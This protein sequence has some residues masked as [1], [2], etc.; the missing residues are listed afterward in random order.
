MAESEALKGMNRQEK[1]DYI[2]DV[3]YRCLGEFG[4]SAVTLDLIAEKANLSKGTLSYYFEN[5]DALTV[6]TMK[7]ISRLVYNEIK[8]NMSKHTDPKRKILS[9]M[10]TLLSIYRE[11]PE[12]IV[13][14]YGLWS[15]SFHVDNLKKEQVFA[16]E[17][18]REIIREPVEALAKGEK[19]TDIEGKLIVLSGIMFGVAQQFFVQPDSQEVKNAAKSVEKVILMI[20]E[21]L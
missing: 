2:L 8:K 21:A 9:A 19:R 10:Q 1:L 4:Y 14:Y 18:F 6:E 3:A 20:C 17:G 5:K 15:Q 16:T 12:I 11:K 13:G 7:Y